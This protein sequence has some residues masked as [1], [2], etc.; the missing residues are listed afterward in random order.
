MLEKIINSAKCLVL[1]GAIAISGCSGYLPIK[2]QYFPNSNVYGETSLRG[3]MECVTT[4]YGLSKEK[5]TIPVHDEDGGASRGQ[6]VLPD[7]VFSIRCTG[8][9]EQSIGTE[10][11]RFKIGG[12]LGINPPTTEEKLQNLPAPY[13]SYGYVKYGPDLI[14]SPFVGVDVKLN[15]KT[16][17]NFE[18]GHIFADYK[19]EVGHYRWSK[20]KSTEK[21]SDKAQG[22]LIRLGIMY[23]VDY[24]AIGI[25]IGFE[26]VD[27]MLGDERT[28]IDAC[29]F[30]FMW[31]TKF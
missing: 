22:N 28:R 14:I 31:V 19:Y 20:Y 3:K 26:R 5:R 13:E 10:N 12:D 8:G 24:R 17:L 21:D 11:L 25:G 27:S 16:T 23:Q 30:N 4:K 9:I 1:A 18:V 15:K 7:D 6:V 29:T 2:K